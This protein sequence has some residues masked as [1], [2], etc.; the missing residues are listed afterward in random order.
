[1]DDHKPILIMLAFALLASGGAWAWSAS[2]PPAAVTACEDFFK[3]ALVAPESYK[4]RS[5]G[6]SWEPGAAG[7]PGR[8]VALVRYES[9]TR[10]GGTA[11]DAQ[12][13]RFV[14]WSPDQRAN[15]F[16]VDVGSAASEN[17]A[18]MLTNE[19]APMK[20]RPG[21]C[22]SPGTASDVIALLKHDP[23]TPR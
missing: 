7:Q 4:R 11:L 12:V 18:W 2:R 21:C 16:K 9:R 13:C 20:D 1:M 19:A 14:R 15:D 22:D 23:L 17:L 5:H 8:I 3:S 6:V 10:N